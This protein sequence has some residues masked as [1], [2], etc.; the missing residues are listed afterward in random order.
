MTAP[1]ARPCRTGAR[2]APRSV[3]AAGRRAR[4]CR[5]R[6]AGPRRAPR[7]PPAEVVPALHTP[8]IPPT[9]SPARRSGAALAAPTGL[10]LVGLAQGL[11]ELVLGH[12]RPASYVELAR[13]VHEVALRRV[14]VD[15]GGGLPAAA[16]RRV[17][18]P[19]GLWVGR[20]LL[21][22]RLPVVPDLLEGVLQSAERDAV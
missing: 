22:L 12:R 21:A 14:R 16:A 11:D 8:P 15:A 20:T 2:R 3:P 7:R 4:R 18:G 13:E 19:G 9:T 1:A 10:A 5:A 17:P 6:A